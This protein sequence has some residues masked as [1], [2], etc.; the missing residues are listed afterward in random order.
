MDK[1]LFVKVVIDFLED[2]R[3]HLKDGVQVDISQESI[4]LSFEIVGPNKVD[5]AFHLEELSRMQKLNILGYLADA[6]TSRFIHRITSSTVHNRIIA[7]EQREI[8]TELK[9]PIFQ[10]AILILA[11]ASAFIIS[12]LVI[13]LVLYRKKMKMK[14]FTDTISVDYHLLAYKKQSVYIISGMENKDKEKEAVMSHQFIT[15]T[16]EIIG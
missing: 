4:V 13:L 12:S 8:Y 1:P 7:L 2:M 14:N 3:T 15:R 10:S 6:A 9:T 16:S 11:A 5:V